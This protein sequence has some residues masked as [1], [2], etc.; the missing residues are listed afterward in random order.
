[1]VINYVPTRQHLALASF[2]L[3]VLTAHFCYLLA[4]SYGHVPWCMPYLDS[5]TSI[6]STGR[7]MPEY[8]LFK[9]G[10]ISAGLVSI[11]FWQLNPLWLDHLGEQSSGNSRPLVAL[12]VAAGLS[13]ILYTLVLGHEGDIPRLLRRV[14]VALY[15][16]LTYI[17]QCLLLMRLNAVC[18]QSNTGITPSILRSLSRLLLVLLLVGMG[19]VSLE[20]FP[21]YKERLENALE[22]Q[23]AM[24]MSLVYGLY[25]WA[26]RQSGFGRLASVGQHG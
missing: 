16:G 20:L 17:A 26:W 5:C 22:W 3:P 14:G 19:M 12:G 13:L 23:T 2:L 15:F 4:A 6:S 7:S 10:M 1:M 8:L 24:L 21:A 11:R 9:I 25:W 18:R